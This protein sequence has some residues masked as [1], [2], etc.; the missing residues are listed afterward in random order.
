MHVYLVYVSIATTTHKWT[1]S[2]LVTND[3]DI[4]VSTRSTPYRSKR[5]IRSKAQRQKSLLADSDNG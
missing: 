3:T 5:I 4:Q 1:D 2:H